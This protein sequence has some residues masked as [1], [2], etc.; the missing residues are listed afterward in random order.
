[1]E[2][3]IIWISAIGAVCIG[4]MV[5]SVFFAVMGAIKSRLTSARY[6]K[7]KGFLKDGEV[8]DVHLTSG[9][10]MEGLSFV[11]FMDTAA[12]KGGLPYQLQNMVVFETTDRRRVML[13]GDLIKIIETRGAGESRSA[14]EE[15]PTSLDL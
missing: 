11:G 1:M 4:V 8:V 12:M 2:Y 3:F 5:L 10:V 6:I 15:T 7:L 14:G 13:R 9:K